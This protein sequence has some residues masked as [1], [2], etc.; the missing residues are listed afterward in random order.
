[1]G[2]SQRWYDLVSDPDPG[3]AGLVAQAGLSI[4]SQGY[5]LGVVANRWIFESG[6]L[7][8]KSLPC[9][10]ISVGNITLGGTGKTTASAF[11]ARRL[12]ARGVVPAVILRGHGREA[13]APLMVSDGRDVIAGADE[14]GDEAV[15]LGNLA[16]GAIVAVGRWREAVGEMILDTTEAEAVILDDGFQYF[17]LHRDLDIVLLDALRPLT[18][19]AP[20]FPR[21][22]LREPAHNLQRADQLWITHSDLAGCDGVSQ[23]KAF[24]AGAA[25]GV[26]FVETVHRPVGLRPLAGEGDRLSPTFVRGK[27][28]AAV[29]GIGNPVAFEL[30]LRRLGAAGLTP[31]RYPDHHHYSAS[32]ADDILRRGESSDLIVTTEKDAVRL[33]AAVGASGKAY[34]LR[35]EMEVATNEDLVNSA[36]DRALARRSGDETG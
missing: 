36:L 5:R 32:D 35:V 15:M 18:S 33:P 23:T 20:V 4:I 34:V 7:L 31:I 13:R 1:M 14:A 2:I 29:S 11:V 10:V 3:P 9:P 6:L 22:V 17:R 25:P 26:P 27:Q 16:P 8:R 12:L 21:G 19:A 30:T 28:V 24:A